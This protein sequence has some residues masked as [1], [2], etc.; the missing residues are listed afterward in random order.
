MADNLQGAG[1]PSY[2][3]DDGTGRTGTALDV[4]FFDAQRDAINSLIYSATN[5]NQSPAE[6]TDEVIE[7]RGNV[8]D[9]DTRISTVIDDDGAFVS[10]SGIIDEAG[11]RG[12]IGPGNILSNEDFLIWP[13]SLAEAPAY[14][15]LTD[16][17]SGTDAV[18]Q[19]S[20]T[21]HLYYSAKVTRAA[22]STADT[23]LY[24]DILDT[25]AFAGNQFD[26]EKICAGCW[27]HANSQANHAAIAINDGATETESSAHTGAAGWQW[28]TVEH[29]VDA[30][31]TML[32]FECRVLTDGFAYFDLPT[33]TYSDEYPDKWI[34]SPRMIGTITW[35]FIGALTQGDSKRRY[36][37]ERPALVL[38]AKCFANDDPTGGVLTIDVEKF[39]TGSSW[40]SIFSGAKNILS[41]GHEVGAVAAD[42]DYDHR[43]FT[44]YLGASA[45]VASAIDSVIRLNLDAVNSAVDV[46]FKIV[47]L[48]YMNALEGA[49]AWDDF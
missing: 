10:P 19:E 9:L 5:P 14:W 2:S 46:T 16:G 39:E 48:Q 1:W 15:V 4:T 25:G 29:T 20:T 26:L 38:G 22:G 11:L 43:C 41:D 44:G 21:K 24:Q 7:A 32:R 36:P 42:G 47:C 3:D 31:A 33:V 27:V 40:V 45:A 13:L 12:A 23:V 30:T 37:F 6:T 18:A 17:G 35:D 28:L 49:R 8:T 34:P